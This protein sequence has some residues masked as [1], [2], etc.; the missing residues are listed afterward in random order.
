[1]L[2]FTLWDLETM[3]AHAK[4]IPLR[5]VRNEKRTSRSSA[6]VSWYY[7]YSDYLLSLFKFFT[8]V[9]IVRIGIA[10]ALGFIFIQ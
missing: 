8:L 10:N 9:N 5:A 6:K 4:W 2:A 1:M 3:H 7:K